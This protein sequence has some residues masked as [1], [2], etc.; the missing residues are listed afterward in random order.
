MTSVQ[1][2]RYLPSQLRMWIPVGRIDLHAR[3]TVT[4]HGGLAA[5]QGMTP[6]LEELAR[7]STG[8]ECASHYIH[9]A[10][11]PLPDEQR[12]R[13]GQA[14]LQYTACVAP[15]AVALPQRTATTC[16]VYVLVRSVNG[17]AGASHLSLV[18][19][20]HPGLFLVVVVVVVFVCARARTT[21][22]SSGGDSK[23]AAAL[24]LGCCGGCS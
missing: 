9:R 17:A 15:L 12:R 1:G 7:V 13:E 22:S 10:V 2:K 16:L 6:T 23:H 5:H 14:R 11:S 18:A 20:V 4:A 24:R 21:F 8:A 3:L 19:R